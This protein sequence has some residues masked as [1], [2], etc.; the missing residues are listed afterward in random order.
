MIRR[1]TAD[2]VE[3]IARLYERSFATLDFLPVLHT[4]DEHREWFTRQLAAHEGWV[5]D[6]DGVRGFIVLTESELMYL[7]LDVGW[8]GH[9]IGSELLDQAKRCRP[10]G[11]TLWT[12]QQNVG[13]RHFYERH[14]LVPIEF[15][16][17]EGNEE[18]MPDVKY[19]WKPS[20]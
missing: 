1:A 11:F 17:G 7:Y 6:E 12:F 15:T 4:L 5:W 20:V 9:G 3:E 16:E 18:K 8:T 19:E 13:A 14:G 10:G 2:D